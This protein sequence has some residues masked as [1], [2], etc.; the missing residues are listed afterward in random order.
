MP[1]SFVPYGADP[2][3]VG[4]RTATAK[5]TQ[6]RDSVSAD[7][8]HDLVIPVDRRIV[9]YKGAAGTF[10]T[11][12]RAG[13][14]GQK[15][16][17]IHN[18]TGSS[19]LV[20]VLSLNVSMFDTVVK[21]LTV[22]PPLIRAWRFTTVPTNGTAVAKRGTDT[23]QSS[24]SSVTVWQDASADGTGSATTL[25]VTLPAAGFVSQAPGLRMVTGAGFETNREMGLLQFT[26]PQTL[27]A[28]EGIAVFLDYTVA[29]QNP[30]TDMWQV[31][32]VWEEYTTY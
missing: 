26:G 18:A 19:I 6:T 9:T 29:T 25:T 27:R 11:L 1:D 5:R 10:R 7:F 14:T 8:H 13:T 31:D 20:D 21:A 12:G 30:I 24:S 4:R 2:G 32:C 15:I 3:T 23:S 17:A 16:F 22:P 28:L